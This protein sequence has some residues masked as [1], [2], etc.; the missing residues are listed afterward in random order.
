M[1]DEA[2]AMPV[3]NLLVLQGGGPTPVLNASLYAVIA[4]ARRHRTFRRIFGACDGVAGILKDQVLD[5]SFLPQSDLKRLK[6][7]PGASLG[8][9][10][11][12][13]SDGDVEQ[14][15]ARLRE[16]DVR[17][18]VLIG[19]NGSMRGADLI[20]QGA[21]ALGHDLSVIGV[22]KT[23]DNDIPV[24][25]RCPGFGSAARYVA[26]SVRDL[27][28]DVQSLPQ[29]VSI[30]ET[31]GRSAGWLAASSML[32]RADAADADQAPHLVYLPERPFDVDR[33]LADLDRVVTRL[34]W[35]IVVVPEG[36]LDTAGQPIFET[37][38]AAQRDAVGRALP[39]GVSAHLAGVVAKRMGIRCRWEKPGLC[40]RASALHVSPVDRED[41]VEV[42]LAAVRGALAG[43]TGAM[44]S[45]R[46]LDDG[47]HAKCDSVPLARVAGGDRRLPMPWQT[48]KAETAIKPEFLR[49]VR[50][51][52]GGL[53]EYP[54]SLKDLLAKKPAVQRQPV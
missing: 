48:E 19:G 47:D 26:Q 13:L 18:L 15:I 25:D 7:A 20:A 38:S 41:A 51:I 1:S 45:L 49:Y 4:E 22:P 30:Y 52:V 12:K 3:G 8:S 46:P 5:L 27:A 54:R 28:M 23:V 17:Y 44:V 36:L 2:D 10:R 14:I 16:R 40:G 50:H 33:F 39:G 43:Q 31:M 34:G 29:P 53:L 24:T 9:T 37:A 21:A 32:A 42:G 11:H 6:S 35:A